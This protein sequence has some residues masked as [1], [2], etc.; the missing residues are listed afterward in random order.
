VG[1]EL[2]LLE[3]PEEIDAAEDDDGEN[4]SHRHRVETA[5]QHAVIAVAYAVEPAIDEIHEM[6]LPAAVADLMRLQQ[7]RAHHG[8]ERQRDDCRNG[9]RADEGESE[10]GEE[11]AG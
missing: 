4:P 10:F 7:P 6:R 9:D 8:R 11:R 3:S 5:M 1:R 2:G